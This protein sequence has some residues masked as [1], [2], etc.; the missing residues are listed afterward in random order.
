MSIFEAT[1]GISEILIGDLW[2][3]VMSAVKITDEDKP[4]TSSKTLHLG[5]YL[6]NANF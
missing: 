2:S 3:L 6:S 4:L 5:N 1:S